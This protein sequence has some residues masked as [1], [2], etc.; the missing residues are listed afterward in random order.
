MSITN[1]FDIVYE[2]SESAIEKLL[3]ASGAFP[4]IISIPFS[5]G[6]VEG[7]VEFYFDPVEIDFDTRINDGVRL[8]IRFCE[9]TIEVTSPIHQSITDL[10]G[11][12]ILVGRIEV[13]APSPREER[14]IS[15]NRFEPSEVSFDPESETAID[16]AGGGVITHEQVEEYLE[17]GIDDYLSGNDFHIKEITINPNS[18]DPLEPQEIDVCVINEERHG[19]EHELIEEKDALAI[20]IT[21]TGG[22]GGDRSAFT[23]SSFLVSG[24]DDTIMAIDCSLYLRDF[25][26]PTIANFFLQSVIDERVAERHRIPSE[27][28][29]EGIRRDVIQEVTDEVVNEYFDPHEPCRLIQTVQYEDMDI[30]QFE[31]TCDEG[32]IALGGEVSASD[33]AWSADGSFNARVFLYVRDTQSGRR[34]F[35]RVELN[36]NVE[37]QIKWWIYLLGGILIPNGV[38]IVQAI[39]GFVTNIVNRMAEELIGAELGRFFSVGEDMPTPLIPGSM[40]IKEGDIVISGTLRVEDAPILAHQGENSGFDVTEGTVDLDSGRCFSVED[41]SGGLSDFAWRRFGEHIIK[42][43]NGARIAYLGNFSVEGF[44]GIGISYLARLQYSD[45]LMI[46][47]AELPIDYRCSVDE[48]MMEEGPSPIAFAMITNEGRYSKVILYPISE[49]M[50]HYTGEFHMGFDF[51][52][53]D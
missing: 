28:D 33:S 5:R 42:P 14:I 48:Y 27:E 39:D 2:F 44:E 22:G 37:V 6:G 29:I 34:I 11:W 38:L 18:S 15:I 52:T 50:E 8:Q 47:E 41:D 3:G 12:V 19:W 1:G 43:I 53:Y 26:R 40:L 49:C 30:T 51:V 16:N 25:G 23:T 10:S 36:V 24:Y 17:N 7:Q 45:S 21:T 32:F 46:S 20:L 35:P 4:R 31:A 9:S 13:L